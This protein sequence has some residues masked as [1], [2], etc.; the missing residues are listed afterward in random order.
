DVQGQLETADPFVDVI[1]SAADFGT[2]LGGGGSA[3]NAVPFVFSVNPE[4]PDQHEIVFDL[5][6]SE[7]PDTLELALTAHAPDLRVVAY[8]IDDSAGGNGNGI[9]EAGE[10]IALDITVANEGSV[11]VSAVQGSLTGGQYLD[12]DP[13]PVAYGEL[14]P[15]GSVTGGPFGVVVSPSSP[16]PYTTHLSLLLE[17]SGTYSRSRTIAFGIGNI[18]SDDMEVG[19]AAWIHYPSGVEYGDEWHLETYRNHTHDGATSWKCGG[20]GAVDYSS[21]LYSILESSPFVLPQLSTLTF[22]HWMDAEVSG[23]YQ[24]YCYDGGLVE[25]SIE[26]GVWEQ[27]TPEGGYPYLMRPGSNPLPEDTPVFSGSHGWEEASFN[28]AGY[29]GNARIRFVFASDAAETGEGWY[30]DDVQLQLGFSGV[31]ETSRVEGL[32]LSLARS[33]PARQGASFELAL[34][35]AGWV[36]VNIYDA[37]GRRIRTLL[38]A[39]LQAGVHPLVWDGHDARGVPAGAGVYWAD[40]RVAD[41]RL[42][43]RIVVAR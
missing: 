10:S 39:A 4:V 19:G 28:L 9:A 6:V 3:S 18:F 17:D 13:A 11:A 42:A 25:I 35:E 22:W 23:T 31:E 20:A 14:V 32:Q 34:P 2:I 29:A 36:A 15:E 41:Q 30:V 5:L 21:N 27:I 43:V 38:D 7:L 16:D 8:E 33:N 24:G 12:A 37:A 40:A 1:V 26:G